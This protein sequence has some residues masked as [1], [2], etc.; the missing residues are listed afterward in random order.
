MTVTT[1]AEFKMQFMAAEKAKAGQLDFGG[2]KPIW[3]VAF[4]LLENSQ[5]WRVR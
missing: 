4:R 3:S 2:N 5:K 1:V